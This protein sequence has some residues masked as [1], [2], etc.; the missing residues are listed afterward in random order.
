MRKVAA[1]VVVGVAL[2]GCSDPDPIDTPEATLDA[3]DAVEAEGMLLMAVIQGTEAPTVPEE[4]LAA[5]VA[6]NVALRWE[7]TGCASTSQDGTVLTITFDN[8]NGPRGVAHVTGTLTASL[9]VIDGTAIVDVSSPAMSVNGAT[10]TVASQVWAGVTL[11]AVLLDGFTQGP[12]TG[13]R[14]NEVERWGSYVITWPASSECSSFRGEW[15]TEAAPLTDPLKPITTTSDLLRC[16]GRCP[17]GTVSRIFTNGARVTVTLD[18]STLAHWESTAGRSG[19][20]DLR[21]E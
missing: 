19:T 1:F 3:S 2:V 16:P 8:C 6:A 12:A 11:D 17:H 14:G 10:L 21:C 7:P 15:D 20:L 9:Y 13:P 5:D 18:G 4:Q